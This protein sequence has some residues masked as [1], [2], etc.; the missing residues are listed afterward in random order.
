[1]KDESHGNRDASLG[2][3]RRKHLERWGCQPGTE[4]FQRPNSDRQLGPDSL[5][6]RCLGGDEAAWEELVRHHTRQVYGL[7]YRFTGSAQEA[8]DLTQEVF[9]R[10]FR[11]I[12]TFRCTEGAFTRGWRG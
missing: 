10:V 6:S 4:C 12:K 8:Q 9:L 5:V 1:M 2:A 3:I 7:C 11:T